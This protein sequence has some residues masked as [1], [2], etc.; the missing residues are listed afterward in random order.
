MFYN[1]DSQPCHLVLFKLRFHLNFFNN[2]YAKSTFFTNTRLIITVS[3]PK[4]NF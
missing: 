3:S 2:L 1:S 4:R